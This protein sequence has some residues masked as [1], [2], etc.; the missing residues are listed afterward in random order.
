MEE[1]LSLRASSASSYKSNFC[2]VSVRKTT[3]KMPVTK[4]NLSQ[5]VD[6]AVGTPEVGAVNFNVLHTLLHAMLKI[7]FIAAI[8]NIKG[9]Q[10]VRVLQSAPCFDNNIPT[11]YFRF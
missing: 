1:D 6:L 5:M 9:P 2:Q 11:Q 3:I 8:V 4:V 10:F 7:T